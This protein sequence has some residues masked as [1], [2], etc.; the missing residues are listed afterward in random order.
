MPSENRYSTVMSNISASFNWLTQVANFK[1]KSGHFQAKWR[2][3]VKIW[4]SMRLSLRKSYVKD[5]M[6]GEQMK[7]IVCGIHGISKFEFI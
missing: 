6:I 5:H 7:L 1:W 4:L 2:F 3:L